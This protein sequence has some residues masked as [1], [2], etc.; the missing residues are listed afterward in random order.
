[1]EFC[2]NVNRAAGL[3]RRARAWRDHDRL[4][5]QSADLFHGGCIVAHDDRFLPQSLKVAGEIVNEAVVVVD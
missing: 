4:R 3:A 2:D 1:M 5:I